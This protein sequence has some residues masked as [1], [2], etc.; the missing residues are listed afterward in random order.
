MDLYRCKVSYKFYYLYSD[1]IDT[2]D[3]GLCCNY[4]TCFFWIKWYLKIY[5]IYF[6]L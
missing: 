3:Y 6:G 5:D 1:D 2:K 4:K